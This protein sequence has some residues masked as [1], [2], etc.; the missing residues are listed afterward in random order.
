[1]ER[2]HLDRRK[3]FRFEL[4][5]ETHC[6]IPIQAGIAKTVVGQVIDISQSGFRMRARI[7]PGT[8]GRL[9][10]TLQCKASGLSEAVEIEIV[11]VASSSSGQ[12]EIGAKFLDAMPIGVVDQFV[13]RPM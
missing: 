13:T 9:A 4:G 5:F 6:L 1:M 3:R 10:A 2:A 12:F 11:Y 8:G 7:R